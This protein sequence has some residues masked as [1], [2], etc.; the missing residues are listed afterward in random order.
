MVADLQQDAV[1]PPRAVVSTRCGSIRRGIRELFTGQSIVGS[2][3]RRNVVKPSRSEV[4]PK[5]TS[6][7]RGTVPRLHR[8]RTAP[9]T[10]PTSSTVWTGHSPSSAYM[11]ITS[12]P[13]TP[14]SLQNIQRSMSLPQQVARNS[15]QSFIGVGPEEQHLA[16][17]ANRGRRRLARRASRH[18]KKRSCA[19]DLT[20]RRIRSKFIACCLSAMLLL[21]VLTICQTP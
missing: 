11:P 1:Q 18:P 8:A 19:I 20:D 7:T 17:L 6:P 10:L 16:D 21:T 15:G 12:R 3:T 9:A 5:A 14:N 13:I 4:A 2:S